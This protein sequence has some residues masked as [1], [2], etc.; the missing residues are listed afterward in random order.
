MTR[1]SCNMG[2]CLS[3]PFALLF[4]RTHNQK[5]PIFALPVEIIQHISAA[6]L[7]VDDAAS[8]ALSS[9][10]MLMILGTQTLRSLLSD[11]NATERT[12]FLE[13]LER[14]L[15]DWLLCPHCSKFHRVDPNAHP[16]QLWRYWNEKKCVRVNGV[17]TIGCRYH[18]RYEYVQ[19]LM[20]DYRLG[21]PIEA[22]L[23]GLSD[24]HTEHLPEQSLRRI[25]TVRIV[26]GELVL[27]VKYTLKLPKNW[28]TTLYQ[29]PISPLCPHITTRFE[30]SIFTKALDCR[31]MHAYRKQPLCIECKGLKHCPKC[32]TSFQVTVKSLENPGTKIQVDV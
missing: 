29:T 28:D 24:R 18:I 32:R 30:N 21:R 14:N 13:N 20:R 31:V 8:L 17:V 3:R 23:T 27:K 15:P 7:P 12:R 9:R 11:R 26:G 1:R 16:L 10:S 6:F 2:S 4:K 5:A 22:Y 19:L 25:V